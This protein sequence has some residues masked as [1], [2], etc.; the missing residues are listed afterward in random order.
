MEPGYNLPLIQN[1]CSNHLMNRLGLNTKDFS[2][3]FNGVFGS[4][5]TCLI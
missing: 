4:I 2:I 1:T 3:R 5:A